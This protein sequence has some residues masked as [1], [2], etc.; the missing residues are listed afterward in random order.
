MLTR[1]DAVP[2]R[3]C[4]NGETGEATGALEEAIDI[5]RLLWSDQSSVRY[6]GRHY[7]LAGVRPGPRPAH[8]MGI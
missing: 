4:G 2:G 3:A 8:P 6:E 1:G 7:R 5:I